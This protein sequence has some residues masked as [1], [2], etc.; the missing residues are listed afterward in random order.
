MTDN[1]VSQVPSTATD[2]DHLLETMNAGVFKE[3]L[4]AY[5]SAAASGVVTFGHGKKTGK[6]VIAFSIKQV[7][8]GDQVILSHTLQSEI[9]TKRGKKAEIDT[10]DTPYFVGRGG[11]MT[12]DQPKENGAGQYSLEAQADGILRRDRSKQ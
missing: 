1:N 3:K 12:F 2:I 10:T 7:G 11:K 8:E 9:P 4:E 5:L 6:V